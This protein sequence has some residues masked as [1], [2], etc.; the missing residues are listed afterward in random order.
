MPEF[1]SCLTTHVDIRSWKTINVCFSFHSVLM[2][3]RK[4][5]PA[6][7]E[8]VALSRCCVPLEK[9][10]LFRRPENYSSINILRAW[11]GAARGMS[12]IISGLWVRV[13]TLYMCTYCGTCCST[14]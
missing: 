14:V 3:A 1:E 6:G 8:N 10:R 7:G 4:G 9:K 13:Y 12:M 2:Y 5:A 11:R